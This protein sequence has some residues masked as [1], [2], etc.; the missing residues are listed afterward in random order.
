MQGTDAQQLHW[1]A[2]TWHNETAAVAVSL[3]H[4]GVLITC[5]RS[6]PVQHAQRSLTHLQSVLATMFLAAVG[7]Y[8]RAGF[9]S[10]AC[11]V[12]QWQPA[13]YNCT[14]THPYTITVSTHLSLRQGV[15]A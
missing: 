3:Q 4:D 9:Q 7:I 1:Q 13:Q 8:T 11:I 5:I 2:D 6:V 10:R 12:C 15:R 14:C